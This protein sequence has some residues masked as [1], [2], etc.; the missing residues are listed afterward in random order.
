MKLFYR[1]SV[2]QNKRFKLAVDGVFQNSN[3]KSENLQATDDYRHLRDCDV[4]ICATNSVQPFLISELLKQNAIIIDISVPTNVHADVLR[5]RP[6]VVA[7]QGGLVQLPGSQ[8]VASTCSPTPIGNTY[9]CLAETLMM[10]FL[11]VQTPYSIGPLTKAGVLR[12]LE[13]SRKVG[14]ELGQLRQVIEI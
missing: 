9:A 10:G 2:Q 12:A 3:I 13:D 1:E 4:I 14:Y 5:N 7:M 8:P 11:K 6:D